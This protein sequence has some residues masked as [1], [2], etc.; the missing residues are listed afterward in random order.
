MSNLYRELR[1]LN[2]NSE[3]NPEPNIEPNPEPNIE[4]NREDEP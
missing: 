2:P 1:T 3:P 4:P